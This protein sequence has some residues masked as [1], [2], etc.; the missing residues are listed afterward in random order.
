MKLVGERR[1]LAAAI[2]AFYFIAY[3]VMALSGS[4]PSDFAKA[5]YAI[6]GVYGLA[7]FALVAGYFWARWYAVGV[8]LYGV[9]TAAVGMWQIGTEPVLV[10]VGATHLAATAMLWGATMS[11]PYDGQQ[12]WRQKFH[13]D[14]N[15]VQRLGRS[16]IRAGV[17]LPFVLLYAL[18]PKPD[19][20]STIAALAALA[21]TGLGIRGLV[22]LK[23]W[24][25]L[26]IGAA[27][28]L[29]VTLAA[30]DIAMSGVTIAA[31]KPSI[32]GGLLIAAAVPFIAPMIRWVRSSARTA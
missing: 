29:L 3:G 18:A 2:F 21:L 19:A 26:A 30:S 25:V 5:F 17:S 16:V 27:G 9:I 31:F 8:G 6:A 15:A 1:A 4:I 10:F 12:A 23:T 7:F 28:A 32:A 11:E 13:M 14:E 24:G 22:Q 20:G